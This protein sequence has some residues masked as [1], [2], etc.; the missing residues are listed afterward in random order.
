MP[1]PVREASRLLQPA[2]TCRSAFRATAAHLRRDGTHDHQGAVRRPVCG[3]VK[4]GDVLDRCG[5]EAVGG[6]DQRRGVAVR[7]AVDA[8]GERQRREGVGIVATR[9]SSCEALL[10]QRARAPA[11]ETSGRC[12]TS[13]ISGSA[14]ASRRNRHVQLKRRGIDAARRGEIGEQRVE[15]VGDLDGRTRAGALGEHRRR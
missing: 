15:R 14:S 1:E 5:R 11:S 3:L 2:P 7:R 6:A 4:G 10:P 8:A 13:A 9:C 12:A